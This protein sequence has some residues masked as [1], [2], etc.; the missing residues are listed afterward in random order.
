MVWLAS[1]LTDVIAVEGFYQYDWKPVVL[2]PVGTV[3]SVLDLYGGDGVHATAR[4]SAT[5]R[6]PISARSRSAVRRCRRA[7]SV[8]I[9]SSIGFPGARSIG[10][11]TAGST[12]SAC[13]RGFST[14]SPRSSACTT[15]ATTAACRSSRGSPANAAA[16]AATS[17]ASVAAV[18]APLVPVYVGEGLDPATA[19]TTAANTAQSL[20]LSRYMNQ[21]G[22][23]VEFPGA[24][25]R[26]RCVVQLLVARHR[27]AGI[28][29]IFATVRLSLSSC[30]S[31]PCSAQC[32]RRCNSIRTSARRRSASSVP[33]R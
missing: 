24:R 12:A 14:A 2:P 29:R 15:S 21:A 5:G 6:S 25:R 3:F 1:S 11:P 22:Y 8:S 20:T 4:S 31:T 19:A 33:T 10:R 13:S 16:I 9:R 30:R 26:T 23:L 32:C 18:A 7:R 27:H 28:R 17:A